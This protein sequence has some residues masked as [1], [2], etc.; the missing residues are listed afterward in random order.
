MIKLYAKIFNKWHTGEISV[1]LHDY[2][3]H[4]TGSISNNKHESHSLSLTMLERLKIG[5]RSTGSHFMHQKI[6]KNSGIPRSSVQRMLK[7]DPLHLYKI[8]QQLNEDNPDCLCNFGGEQRQN[9]YQSHF[10]YSTSFPNECIYY[11]F[12][13]TSI[14]IVVDAIQIL[15][16][17]R[18]WAGHKMQ[19]L[20]VTI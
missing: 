6:R 9:F 5:P 13:V 3:I 18:G 16:F 8:G 2:Q 11:P 14:N 20:Y 4:M 17:S 15:Q 12:M 7:K 19:L 10:L 1:I